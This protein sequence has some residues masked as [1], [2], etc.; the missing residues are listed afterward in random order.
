MLLTKRH[1][2]MLGGAGALVVA[3]GAGAVT[4]HRRMEA[5]KIVDITVPQYTPIHVTLD[6]AIASDE[7]RPGDHFE[8][9]ISQP[10]VVDGRTVIPEGASAEGLVVDVHRSGRLKG[11]GSL[12]LALERVEVGGQE[13]DVETDSSRRVGGRH[14]KH[15][16][17]WIG[18]GAGG[19]ALIGAIA[20][21]GEGALIGGPVGAGAGTALA[22]LT[23]RKDVHLHPETPLTFEL[24]EPLT[25]PMKSAREG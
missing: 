3:V 12:R 14:K 1:Y 24:A 23:G 11:R 7:N 17:E 13:Y 9:T 20:G 21:G 22:F 25:I 10:V 16:L 8:A 5:P 18:G 4:L 15:D 2:L 19:A 6:Q